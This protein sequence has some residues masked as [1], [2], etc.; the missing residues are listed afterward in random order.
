M[1]HV[2]G[3]SRG[4]GA[5]AA[6]GGG[7]PPPV[8]ATGGIAGPFGT[9]CVCAMGVATSSAAS[10][11]ETSN[12]RLRFRVCMASPSESEYRVELHGPRRLLVV[13]NHVEVRVV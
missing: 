10:R 4:P 3:R 9:N 2:D 7:D 11:H 6:A 1:F 8:N 5:G 13:L 12:G